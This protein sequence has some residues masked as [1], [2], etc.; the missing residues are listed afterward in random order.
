MLRAHQPFPQGAERRAEVE[1]RPS[2]PLVASALP[3]GGG[4]RSSGGLGLA[5]GAGCRLEVEVLKHVVVDLGGD[6]LLL[7]HLADGLVGRVCSEV[8][9]ALRHRSL[10]WGNDT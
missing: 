4:G 1:W 6:F 3:G 2:R 8:R 9:P 7:Q 10:L 5:G